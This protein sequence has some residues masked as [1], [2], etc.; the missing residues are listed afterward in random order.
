M[1]INGVPAARKN[2]DESAI[3]QLLSLRPYQ[4]CL[5]QRLCFSLTVLLFFKVSYTSKKVSELKTV[6][7]AQLN[8]IF[9]YSL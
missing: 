9:N 7:G 8:A 4:R 5:S 6:E 1:P 2:K 3:P